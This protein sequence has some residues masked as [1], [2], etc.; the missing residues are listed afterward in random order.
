VGGGQGVGIL[1]AAVRA[2]ERVLPRWLLYALVWPPAAVR[3]AWELR[4]GP[5]RVAVRMPQSMWTR[6]A[7]HFRMWVSRVPL[8][9][10]KLLLLWPDRLRLPRWRSCLTT[11]GIERFERARAT[12][13]PVILATLHFGPTTAALPLLRRDGLRAAALVIRNPAERAPFRIALQQVADRVNGLN[14]VPALMAVA[15]L[16][17]AVE[18][19]SAGH[20]LVLSVDGPRGRHLWS[21]IDDHALSLSTAVCQM[22]AMR[23][24]VIVPCLLT[25]GP[26]FRVTMHF[27]EPVPDALVVDYRRHQAAC[28]HLHREFLPVVRAC[29]E[30]CYPMLTAARRRP[31]AS[32]VTARPDA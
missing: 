19:L 14:G 32:G 25:A 1:I 2:A 23:Q 10:V 29:P 8:N 15:D 30:Q 7:R 3:T 9:A 17:R 12:G 16:E 22:A 5:D 13:R 31:A 27:G 26:L 21:T 11:T 4:I 28:D 24:A 6:T 18:F 20:V